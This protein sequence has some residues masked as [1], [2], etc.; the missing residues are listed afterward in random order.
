MS[1]TALTLKFKMC[2]V[3]DEACSWAEKL[4]PDINLPPLMPDEDNN[5]GGSLGPVHTNPFSNE[6]GAVLLRIR[7]SSTLQRRK[8]SPKREPLE[9]AHHWILFDWVR[10][11][12]TQSKELSS[13]RFVWLSS[14]G[15]EIELPQ[16]SVF[17]LVRLPHWLCRE[18]FRSGNPLIHE[19]HL[20]AYSEMAN[21]SFITSLS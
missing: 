20:M 5:Y 16:C 10:L 8:R 19:G 2:L 4:F 6:N 9:N 12:R 3:L 7:L 14:I 17:D 11:N 13:I 18:I 15:L 21:R 1:R